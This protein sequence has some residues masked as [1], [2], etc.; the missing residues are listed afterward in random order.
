LPQ[1]FSISRLQALAIL[2]GVRSGCPSPNPCEGRGELS[3]RNVDTPQTVEGLGDGTTRER[4][5]C[6]IATAATRPDRLHAGCPP[7]SGG[8]TASCRQVPAGDGQTEC[9]PVGRV[10]AP[11]TLPHIEGG[12]IAEQTRR[13][14]TV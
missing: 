9:V 14:A 8:P 10:D 11:G 6:D 13:Q 4:S 12:L 1:I 2:D 7:G 3:L 5:K